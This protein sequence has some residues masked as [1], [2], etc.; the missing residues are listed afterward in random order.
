MPTE[1]DTVL[2]DS[3]EIAAP[4]ASVWAMVSDVR[5]MSEWSPQVQSTRLRD[6]AQD[7]AVGVG[8]TNLNSNGELKWKTHGTV[9]RMEVEREIA[10]RIEENWTVWTFRLEPTA[11]GTKLTQRREAPDGYAPEALQSVENYFGGWVAFTALMRE[12]M[13]QTLQAIKT[14]V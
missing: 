8:F 11:L 13:H 3:I 9:V 2:E 14:A 10:F 1:Y 12:G 7:V 5:R 6:G 4:P